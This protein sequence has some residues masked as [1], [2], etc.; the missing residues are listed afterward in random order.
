[1][2]AEPIGAVLG[3]LADRARDDE[4]LAE[5]LVFLA[6]D[7]V[8][9][10]ARPSD[11]VLTAAR[12]VNDRRADARRRALGDDALS[13]AEVVELI[14]SISDR[15]AVDRRRHR[16]RLLGTRVGNTVLHPG[17]QF[18][19]RG[20]DSRRGLARILDAL[21]E[22]TDDPVAANALMTTPHP[23][24]DGRTIAQLFADGDVDRAVTVI[25]LAKDQS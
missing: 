9:P 4:A 17:W 15:R 21:A 23:G 16:G 6:E 14:A 1:M 24:L 18:D 3:R 25:R 5:T 2:A 20:G 8:D 13:T 19:R 12:T 7:D 11:A 10:F 22:V